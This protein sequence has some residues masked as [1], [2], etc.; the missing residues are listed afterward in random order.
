M[1]ERIKRDLAGFNRQMPSLETVS[2]E[3]PETKN[4]IDH[5]FH[6]FHR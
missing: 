6:G 5:G 3:E 1:E 2:L 4:G